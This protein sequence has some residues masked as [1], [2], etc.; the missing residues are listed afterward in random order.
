M[1]V[2]ASNPRSNELLRAALWPAT[3]GATSSASHLQTAPKKSS[4]PADAV[5]TPGLREQ[6][7]ICTASPSKAG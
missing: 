6:L 2:G 4:L 3:T 1:S 5:R 7:P